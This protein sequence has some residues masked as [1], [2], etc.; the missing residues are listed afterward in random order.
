MALSGPIIV[1]DDR[2]GT[3]P[4]GTATSLAPGDAVTCVRTYTIQPSDLPAVTT[5][6]FEIYSLGVTDQ[7]VRVHRVTTPW[8]E[9]QVT[10]NNF[11]GGFDPTVAGSFDTD[12]VGWRSVDVT[13]L[14]Q[15]WADDTYPNYGLLLEQGLTSYTTYV[16]SEDGTLALRPKLTITYTVPN[17]GSDVLTIQRGPLMPTAVPDALIWQAQPDINYGDFDLLLTGRVDNGE[18]QSLLQFHFALP[19]ASITN[20]ATATATFGTAAITS[21][22]AQATVTQASDHCV[23]LSAASA[24][25]HAIV[26][27][28]SRAIDAFL[29]SL[30]NTVGLAYQGSKPKSE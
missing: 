15:S 7:T 13:A 12:A 14:V 23:P 17:N 2:L 5:A 6:R 20:R 24:A 29:T 19:C 28:F 9:S 16:S 30:N 4:C 21:N 22:T 11:G 26:Q 18:K 1:T 25:Q 10:W 8:N 3:F 27:P